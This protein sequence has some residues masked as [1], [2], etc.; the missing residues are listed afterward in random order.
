MEWFYVVSN[1][2]VAFHLLKSNNGF[3]TDDDIEKAMTK[4]WKLENI[5]H[6]AFHIV[7]SYAGCIPNIDKYLE[8]E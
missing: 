2:N 1:D 6:P 4:M 5:E 7:S 3:L 8:D